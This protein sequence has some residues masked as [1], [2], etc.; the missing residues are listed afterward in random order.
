MG[1]VW[2]GLP[3]SLLKLVF[4]EAKEF[5][6]VL[7]PPAFHFSL[8]V[9]TS[10]P[11]ICLPLI[12]IHLF[13]LASLSTC[14]SQ[15]ALPTQSPGAERRLVSPLSLAGWP[16]G[17]GI[18]VSQFQ[19]LRLPPFGPNPGLWSLQAWDNVGQ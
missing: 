13:P 10:P 14:P 11:P 19:H 4:K 18:P 17:N 15:N 7:F 6:P 1:E 12:L 5:S 16:Y 3:R 9:T 2:A 8:H